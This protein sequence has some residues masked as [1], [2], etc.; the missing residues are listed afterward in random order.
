MPLLRYTEARADLAAERHRHRGHELHALG[1]DVVATV[2]KL[3][4]IARMLGR[5]PGHTVAPIGQHPFDD[6]K[7]LGRDCVAG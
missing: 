5:K 3:P 6:D 7:A 2:G 1:R 4:A